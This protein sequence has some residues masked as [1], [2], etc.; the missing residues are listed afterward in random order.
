VL[1]NPKPLVFLDKFG[2]SSVR[3]I[4]H[5]FIDNAFDNDRIAS[6]IR[7]EIDRLFKVNN[8]PLPVPVLRLDSQDQKS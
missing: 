3:F 6:D 4:L 7:Y 2:E 5:Y 8:I 1:K